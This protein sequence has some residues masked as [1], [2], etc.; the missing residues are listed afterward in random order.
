MTLRRSMHFVPGAN[1]KMLTKS[2]AS[3]ADSL[4]LD[5]ED[6]VTPARKDEARKVVAEWLRDVDFGRQERTVRMNPLDTPWGYDDLRETMV[7]PPDAYL[8]PKPGTL[9]DLM[10][11]DAELRSLER[12]YGH[13]DRS[14]ALILVSTETPLGALNVTTFPSCPRVTALSWG[15]ED[16]AAALGAARNRDR[17]GRYLPVFEHCRTMTLLSATA[18]GVQPIDTVY[19]D[20]NDMAGFLAECEMVAWMGFT[21]KI[22]I[23]PNQIDPINDAFTPSAAD[24]NEANELLEA[25]EIAQAEGNMAFTFNGQMVDAPHLNRAKALL[26]R[27]AAIE[28]AG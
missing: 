11:I 17:D 23:H 2:L 6:A 7:H 19:V 5:L 27:A 4:V 8:V 20:F 24:V 18:A 16:L 14:V 1:E 9:D 22:S 10:T 15:A 3:N 13:P 12:E 25:F 21:G 26:E 28:A